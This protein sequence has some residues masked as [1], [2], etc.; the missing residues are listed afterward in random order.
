MNM[1]ET[2]TDVLIK[3]F[4]PYNAALVYRALNNKTR[5]IILR[6]IH[7]KRKATVSE[8]YVEL[9]LDQPIVSNHLAILRRTGFVQS[10]RL[11]RNIF[12]SINYS[13]LDHVHLLSTR[14]LNPATQGQA[15]QEVL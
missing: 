8:L 6:R 2:E 7:E 15:L 1:A 12:Y 4:W 13:R 3:G 5:Q 14:L 10:E 9:N 11:G